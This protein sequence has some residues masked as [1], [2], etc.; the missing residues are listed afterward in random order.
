VRY[1]ARE[2]N[3]PVKMLADVSAAPDAE[4][5]NLVFAKDGL[6]AGSAFEKALAANASKVAGCVTWAPATTDIPAK[7]PGK[8]RLLVSNKNLLLV[9]D[10]LIVGRVAAWLTRFRGALEYDAN[11]RELQRDVALI[12]GNPL[13]D[14]H[15]VS[16]TRGVARTPVPS[17]ASRLS[18]PSTCTRTR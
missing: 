16:P 12:R 7:N 11:A 9:A 15:H 14:G 2:A 3:L 6:A 10:V 18:A 4:A 13:G 1:L 8:A 5:I 17:C